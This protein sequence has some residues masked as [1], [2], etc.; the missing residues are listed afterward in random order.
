MAP[1]KCNHRLRMEI[2]LSFVPFL[3][4]TANFAFQRFM[5]A[6]QCAYLPFLILLSFQV[7]SHFTMGPLDITM[8]FRTVRGVKRA[9]TTLHKVKIHTVTRVSNDGS[10]MM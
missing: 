7:R 9:A 10:E 6:R 4:H 3:K 5:T 2:T 1:P 8:Q